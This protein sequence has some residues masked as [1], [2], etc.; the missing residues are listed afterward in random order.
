VIDNV[1]WTNAWLSI[2]GAGR[3]LLGVDAGEEQTRK[4]IAG[5][6]RCF[7]PATYQGEYPR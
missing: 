1:V 3:G 4:V 6:C 2:A 7:R 5:E